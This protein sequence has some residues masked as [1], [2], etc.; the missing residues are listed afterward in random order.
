MNFCHYSVGDKVFKN[1]FKALEE[2]STTQLPINFC[3]FENAFDQA[4]WSQEP[5]MSWDQLL[6]IRAQQIAAKNKKIILGFSGGTDSLTVYDVFIRNNIVPDCVHI[7]VK[8][9]DI[10]QSL[11]YKEPLKFVEEE[12]KKYG[13]K[14]IITE[15]TFE[16]LEEWYNTP[17]WI[18][19]PNARIEFTNGLAESQT[20]EFNSAY[21]HNID[22]DYLYVVGLE[23][24][25]CRF[26]QGK[27]ISYQYDQAWGQVLDPRIEP[28]FIS[29]ELPELHVKQSYMLAK[30]IV[31]LSV[32]ENRALEYYQDLRNP[33]RYNYYET[34]TTGCGRFR[35]LAN[36]QLQ[37]KFNKNSRLKFINN[38]IEKV[39]YFGRSL[40]SLHEGIKT[41]E[42]FALNYLSGIRMLSS[43]SSLSKY[44]KN[45]NNLFDLPDY[46]S[47]FYYLNVKINDYKQTQFP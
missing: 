37:K 24:P 45:P 12:R 43:D 38:D 17:E 8:P 39:N 34:A 22:Q 47:K 3:L 29:P 35:D 7:R 14:V 30:Y 28:F 5:A 46:F 41:K 9:N 16:S 20:I 23:K 42:K 2:S 4:D 1:K 13:F 27:F 31:S 32:R 11:F 26:Q 10:E 44:F 21:N 25:Y 15:E 40:T 6:D 33:D 36:S 18:L 19:R